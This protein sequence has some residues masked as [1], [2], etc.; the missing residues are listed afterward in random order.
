MLLQACRAAIRVSIVDDRKFA[1]LCAARL[2]VEPRCSRR[3]VCVFAMLLL[4]RRALASLP[5][6]SSAAAMTDPCTLHCRCGAAAAPLPQRV[7]RLQHQ[8][9]AALLL[10]SPAHQPRSQWSAV[11]RYALR[12]RRHL[13]MT[14]TR[15]LCCN[16]QPAFVLS[17]CEACVLPVRMTPRAC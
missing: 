4:Q 5:R 3:C 10:R 14:G 15:A 8:G 12:P 9:A 11:A 7:G 16:G 6:R 17:R 13:W 1:P 2:R